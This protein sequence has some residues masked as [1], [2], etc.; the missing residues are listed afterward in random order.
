MVATAADAAPYRLVEP[1]T[2]TPLVVSVPHA[3]VLIPPED[4]ATVGADERTVLRD[5][6]LFV[7]RLWRGAPRLGAAF[8]VATHSRYVLD[9]NR[10]PL[11]VDTLVCAE[12]EIPSRPNPRALIWRVSTEGKDVLPRPLTKAELESR[13]ERVHRPYHEKLAALLEDRRRRFGYAILVDGHSMPSVGRV[14]HSDTDRRR[15]DIVPGDV[16]GKSCSASLMTTVCAH[17]T[18]A[19]FEVRANDPYMGGYITRHHGRPGR[20]IHAVQIE[21]NRDL[22]MDEDACTFDDAR[23][24]RLTPVL[25]DLLAALLLLDPRADVT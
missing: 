6:D 22:Y 9:L 8:L 7:D 17:F 15:A 14:G 24:L 21:V 18:E 1:E 16:R 23:A 19:G 10:S 5:A 3:G 2:P 4:R 12:V 20:G 11:D 25:D 13:I